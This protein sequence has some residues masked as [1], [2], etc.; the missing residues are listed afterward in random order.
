MKQILTLQDIGKQ[1]IEETKA[2]FKQYYNRTLKD[3]DAVETIDN[4]LKLVLILNEI[5]AKHRTRKRCKT[6]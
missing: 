3:I 5:Q 6:F 4:M 1:Y 2:L